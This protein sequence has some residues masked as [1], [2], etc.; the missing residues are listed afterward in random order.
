MAR[1][2]DAA[3]TAAMAARSALHAAADIVLPTAIRAV[4]LRPVSGDAGRDVAVCVGAAVWDADGIVHAEGIEF[5]R[6]DR[7]APLGTDT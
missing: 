7:A 3:L 4:T 2:V 1:F 6:V 5:R